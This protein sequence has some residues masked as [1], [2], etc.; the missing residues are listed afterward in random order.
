[1]AEIQRAIGE[2]QRRLIGAQVKVD[3]DL[4][5]NGV[6]GQ[7]G[8]EQG[9]FGEEMGK[10]GSQMGQTAHENHE[11]LRS[12]IDESLKNGKARPVQ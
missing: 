11:K 4:N 1:L 2:L 8:E 6:M 7:F 3:L 5:F 10:L 12:I 9:K